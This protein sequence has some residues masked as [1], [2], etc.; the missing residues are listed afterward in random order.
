MLFTNFT[1]RLCVRRFRH[2]IP[3]YAA[4]DAAIH[5]EYVASRY[6]TALLRIGC[7]RT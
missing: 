7:E 3:Q 1:N 5:A 6:G 4:H 2:N